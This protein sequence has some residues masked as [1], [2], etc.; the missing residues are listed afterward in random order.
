M[1]LGKVLIN[2][3][4]REFATGLTYTALSR[5]RKIE[6]LAFMPFYNYARFKRGVNTGKMFEAR[7]KQDEIERKSDEMN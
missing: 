5:C 6:E 4:D 3:G 2:I 1:S 7:K